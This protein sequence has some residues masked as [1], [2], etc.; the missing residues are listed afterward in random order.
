MRLVLLVLLSFSLAGVFGLGATWWTV[1]HGLP[2]GGLRIG[3]WRAEPA[4]G[5][6]SAHPYLR[7]GIAARGEAPLAYG[8]GLAFT[9]E[10]DDDGRPLDG[11][12][13]Y[14]LTGDLPAARLW[15]LGLF[16][17]DGARFGA[18]P[19]PT[20]TSSAEAVRFLGAPL[21]LELARSARPGNWTRLEHAGPLVLRLSLYDTAL[22]TPLARA[23]P[24]ALLA[25]RRGACR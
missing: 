4:I 7:A 11:A 3:P 14:T 2:A 8:D 12:C 9:A 23:A 16:A 5:G 25:I 19:D 20:G 21:T 10:A 18:G 1:A 17:P 22:G 15:T 13:D 24:D 6:L